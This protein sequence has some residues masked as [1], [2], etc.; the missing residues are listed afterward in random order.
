[1]LPEIEYGQK[2]FIEITNQVHGGSG[3]E[4]GQCLWSPKLDK[5]GKK[6]WRLMEKITPGDIIIHLVDINRKYHWYGISLAASH[7]LLSE[8]QPREPGRW[9]NMAPYQRVNL[10][11]FERISKPPIVSS[12]IS[13]Y[14]K[15][16]KMILK[17]NPNGAFYTLYQ[18]SLR[19][20]QRYIAECPNELYQLFDIYSSTLGFNPIMGSNE[21]IPTINEPLQPDYY[22]PGRVPTTVSRIVRD[23]KLSRDV[24]EMCNWKC[25][26]CGDR[27]LL[28]N[29]NYY[30]EGHH[31]QPLGGQHEGL[32][33]AANIIIL[34]P[35]HHTE[36]DYG[37][38]A[39][40]P[41]TYHV[42]HIDP[43]NK[44]HG[45]NMDYRR[46]DLSTNSIKYHYDKI[47][48]K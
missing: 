30:S 20:A 44:F 32:D 14:H 36:F 13:K 2:V 15:E 6:A 27:V 40:N 42:E 26:I 41:D 48:K 33:I 17:K 3:W 24:K 35:N 8:D 31:L 12:F 47:F 38:I 43:D 7:L 10:K 18:N 11:D 16:L 34:C 39:I 25:Q 45:Q 5:G 22:P 4:L 23:T 19:I 21:I 28:P 1:M 46:D 29:N 37:S 9:S